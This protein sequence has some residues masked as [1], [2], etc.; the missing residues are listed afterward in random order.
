MKKPLTETG[1]IYAALRMCNRILVSHEPTEVIHSLARKVFVKNY[2]K[3]NA[4]NN[5]AA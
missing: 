4:L 3:L 2:C 5:K 1:K